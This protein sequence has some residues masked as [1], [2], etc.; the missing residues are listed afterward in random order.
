MREELKRIHEERAARLRELIQKKFA[1]SG[2]GG[3]PLAQALEY[4][5][6]KLLNRNGEFLARMLENLEQHE[7]RSDVNRLFEL[8]TVFAPRDRQRQLESRNF[9]P[10]PLLASSEWDGGG[11]TALMGPFFLNC[12]YPDME[13]YLHKDYEG[14]SG[15]GKFTYTLRPY[16]GF[17]SAENELYEATRLYRVERPPIFSPWSRRAVTVNLRAG[18]TPGAGED[19][20][21]KKNSLEGLLLG[22]H[23]LM[24]N[25]SITTRTRWDNSYASPDGNCVNYIY[26]YSLPPDKNFPAHEAGFVLPEYADLGNPLNLPLVT[27][28]KGSHIVLES[29]SELARSFK[30]LDIYPPNLTD[31]PE[32][33][34]IFVNACDMDD[35]LAYPRP[36]TAAD[37]NLL[38]S[39]L[40][41]PG[42]EAFYQRKEE[43]P[44]LKRYESGQ[45]YGADRM[46][47]ELAFSASW[48]KFPCR[49]AFTAQE[50]RKPFLEDYAEYVLSYLS[51]RYPEYLWTGE[52]G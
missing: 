4:S 44:A 6:D 18:F 51:R 29:Q 14:E 46:R 45:R 32:D 27:M 38:L 35:L 40:K 7:G 36:R 12:S 42:Y 39:A 26:E 24:W 15:V 34:Q 28:K 3:K 23:I 13:K 5:L 22:D 33:C 11:E 17:I 49:V 31:L 20:L 37:I 21:L 19:L 10:F 48:R 47:G 2:L 52:A 8:V 43:K 50:E 16:F 30:V 1:D 9:F 25:V 41:Q